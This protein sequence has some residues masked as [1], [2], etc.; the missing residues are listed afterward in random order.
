[1]EYIRVDDFDWLD[2]G[3]SQQNKI[4]LFKRGAEAAARFLRR[5][6]WGT[7]KAEQNRRL[8]ERIR[9]AMW[10]LSSLRDLDDIL[11]VFGIEETDPLLGKIEFLRKRSEADP[12]GRYKALW[13]DDSFTYALPVAILWE[14]GIEV[15]TCRSSIDAYSILRKRNVDSDNPLKRIDLILSDATRAEGGGPEDRR[16]IT[17]AEQLLLSPAYRDI[18]VIIYAHERDELEEK[19]IK[20]TGKDLPVN[21]K[22][23]RKKNTIWHRH[24]IAEAVE[25]VYGRVF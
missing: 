17:F 6:D 20:A 18:P 8:L 5:F 21:I 16:G 23:R 7:Y 15:I 19:Y 12:K 9:P 24:L 1:M 25:C 10:E 14:V 3:I 13:I 22:N 2:F 11:S 4:A